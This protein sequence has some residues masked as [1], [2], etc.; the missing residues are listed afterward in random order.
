MWESALNETTGE[1]GMRMREGAARLVGLH[2][3]L[4]SGL[5]LAGANTPPPEGRDDGYLTA[6]EVGWLD[7]SGVEVVKLSACETGLGR[8]QS[9]EGLTG[10]RRAF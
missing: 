6:E 4:L 7:L 3:G 9:G 5:V 2:P 10:L 1:R 8:A